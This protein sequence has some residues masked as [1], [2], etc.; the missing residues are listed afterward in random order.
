MLLADVTVGAP[1][2][3]AARAE[4]CSDSMLRFAFTHL[5]TRDELQR[6][7]GHGTLAESPGSPVAAR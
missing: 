2:V 5:P 3:L 7:V 6:Q 1:D 4:A